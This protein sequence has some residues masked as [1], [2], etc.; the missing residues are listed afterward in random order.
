MMR[1]LLTHGLSD[2]CPSMNEDGNVIRCACNVCLDIAVSH[3]K[4][5]EV[6]SYVLHV[7]PD[8]RSF[9]SHSFMTYFT[10]R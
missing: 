4:G 3:A 7:L 6:A 8:M 10:P 9:M 2:V 1:I 5:V